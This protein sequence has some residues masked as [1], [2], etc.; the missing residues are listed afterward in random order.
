MEI[1]QKC[2][3]PSVQVFD[4]LIVPASKEAKARRALE[5]AWEK[6][7]NHTPWIEVERLEEYNPE[8]ANE[9]RIIQFPKATGINWDE[10]AANILGA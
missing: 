1:L 9:G 5:W 3:V 7:L 4:E 10:V 2:D 6:S 8:E